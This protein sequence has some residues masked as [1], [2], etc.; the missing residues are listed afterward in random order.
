MFKRILIYGVGFNDADY[1]VEKKTAHGTWVCPFFRSWRSMI[2]RCYST[3]CKKIHPS[4]LNATVCPEWLTFSVYK[5]WMEMQDWRGKELDKDV[6]QIKNNHYSP[7][8]CCFVFQYINTLNLSKPNKNSQYPKGVTYRAE[9]NKYRA[10]IRINKKAKHLGYHLTA[11]EASTAYKKAKAS[12]ILSVAKEQ[13]EQR[14]RDG[15][16][17]HAQHLLFS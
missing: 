11:E 9:T 2:E 12:H 15:L 14:V 8:T 17:R 1:T 4:Y 7:E 3:H 16:I 10:A 13:S 6:I 5:S